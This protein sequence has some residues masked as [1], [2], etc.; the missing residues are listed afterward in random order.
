MNTDI[1]SLQKKIL[2]ITIYF[3][4]FCKSHDIT[5]YLMG[6]SALG[7][8][9][10]K[11]FIPWDDDLDVFMTYDNYN[12]FIEK[13]RKNLDNERYYLQE[14]NSEEWPLFFSKIR[15]NGTTF[16]EENIN[17]PN[18]HQGIYIDIMCLN[19]VSSNKLYRY[20]QFLSALLL[21][22]QT[23]NKRG[24]KTNKDLKKKIAMLAAGLLVRGFIKKKLLSFVRG[25]N[26]KET[27][28]V[29]HFFGKAPFS[30][31]SFP[32]VWLGKQRYV[33]FED[34]KLPVPQEAE[35]YL[36]LRF[37]DFMKMPN[38]STLQEYPVHA[39]FVDLENDYKIHLK[40][41]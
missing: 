9:R 11:G 35:K 22:A 2:E 17:N 14:E 29:G 21:T 5:Y 37:G 18:M 33:P 25:L 31:T 10:H 41:N 24:Y 7:A 26:S 28:L 15:M 32:I 3:D 4:N 8:L 1:K 39:L 13:A 6:G 36:T 34:T 12:K 19:N 20:F 38:E 40:S 16:L 23:I 30:K 27:I